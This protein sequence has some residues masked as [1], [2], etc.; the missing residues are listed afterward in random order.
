MRFEQENK[1][2]EIGT[3]VTCILVLLP[4]LVISV[5]N[6]ASGDDYD[7]SI[8]THRVVENGGN[9]FEILKAA[10]DT[11]VN[12]YNTWQGLYT[13]AFLLALQPG[14]F[15]ES[16]YALTTPILLGIAYACLYASFNILNKHF[17]KASKLFVASVSLLVLT[18]LVLWMPS[19][20]EGLFWYNGAMNYIPFAFFDILNLCLLVEIYYGGRKTKAK[21]LVVVSTVLSFLISGGN[22]VTAFANILIL[23]IAVVYLLPQRRYY[24][25]TP[26]VSAVVGFVIMYLAPGT[27][28]RQSA[29]ESQSVG[30]TIFATIKHLRVIAGEW[31]TL[32]WLLSMIVITP[33]VVVI[34]KRI[35]ER[36][37]KHFPIVQ[38]LFAGMIVCG[39]FCVPYLPLGFFGEGRVTNVIWIMFMLLSMYIYI[40]VL[41]YLV[42]NGYVNIDVLRDD[43][44][45]RQWFTAAATVICICMLCVFMSNSKT[46]SSL[47]ALRELGNGVA[48]EYGR[49]MDARIELY[50][51]EK[52]DYVSVPPIQS[53]SELLF[54]RDLEIDP[55]IWPNTSIGAYYGKPIHVV[56]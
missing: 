24:A 43:D 5:Y 50:L 35:R 45:K 12:F 21:V 15:G 55:F 46:S 7:Y 34:V 6:R 36:I 42:V 10:W 25:I 19:A 32:S 44:K 27:A 11:S 52:E 18:L 8:I 56:Y 16:Y 20:I 28:I 48:R 1:K 14:I 3:I 53:K 4:L 54:H 33:F 31:I 49:E 41:G 9:I 51:D 17:V 2:L 40:L 30:T 47:V 37:S 38:I 13:S 29:F 26:F 23:L 39:M 22:H